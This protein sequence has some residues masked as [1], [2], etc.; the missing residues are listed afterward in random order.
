[1]RLRHLSRARVAI[2]TALALAVVLACLSIA[3]ATGG[4]IDVPITMIERS[5]VAR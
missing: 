3:E 5:K 1:M 2:V 4:R